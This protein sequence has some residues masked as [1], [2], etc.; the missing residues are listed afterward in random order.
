M[1]GMAFV[2]RANTAEL[3]HGAL[4]FGLPWKEPV[5]KNAYGKLFGDSRNEFVAESATVLAL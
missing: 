2:K 4:L 3:S 5:R 1:T